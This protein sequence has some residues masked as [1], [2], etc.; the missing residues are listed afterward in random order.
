L[1]YKS[2]IILKVEPDKQLDP[3]TTGIWG[4]RSSVIICL[5][6]SNEI[7][8][9]LSNYLSGQMGLISSLSQSP[10]R[11]LLNSDK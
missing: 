9:G 6:S 11:I 7:K 10:A 2:S 3:T 4:L 5:N 8:I 1:L